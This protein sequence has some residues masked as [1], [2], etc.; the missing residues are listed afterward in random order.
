[1]TSRCAFCG[2]TLYGWSRVAYCNASCEQ[3]DRVLC[4][5]GGDVDEAISDLLAHAAA[6]AD[7]HPIT[8]R[9]ARVPDSL[10]AWAHE[11]AGSDPGE[12]R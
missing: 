5:A 3:A 8:E 10:E 1:M 7:A 6:R 9:I 12:R 2:A 4:G 11:P